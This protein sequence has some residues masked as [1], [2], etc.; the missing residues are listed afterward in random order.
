MNFLTLSLLRTPINDGTK[1]EKKK[2]KQ[3]K[4]QQKSELLN[5]IS[6]SILRWNSFGEITANYVGEL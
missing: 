5:L 4:N 2:K 1:D 6:S 3:T